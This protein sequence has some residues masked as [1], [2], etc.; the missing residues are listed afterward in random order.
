MILE[1]SHIV[2]SLTKNEIDDLTSEIITNDDRWEK[3]QGLTA[4]KYGK[5]IY[6]QQINDDTCETKFSLFDKFPKT[7]DILKDIAG[8]EPL[9]RCYWH[10]LM[11]NEKIDRHD[12][13]LLPFVRKGLLSHRY[14]IYLNGNSN[15]ILEINNQIIPTKEWEYSIVN[16]ALTKKHYYFNNSN[17]PWIFL[18]FDTLKIKK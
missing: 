7:Y 9:S 6:L 8:H 14:Q 18:V 10:K 1:K 15:F 12:D 11:Q 16:F 5:T 4:L 13:S 3:H 17:E 2:R